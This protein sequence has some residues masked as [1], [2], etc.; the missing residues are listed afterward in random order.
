[1]KSRLIPV[2]INTKITTV[3]HLYNAQFWLYVVFYQ[4]GFRWLNYNF[5]L[6]E[7]VHMEQ[8]VPMDLR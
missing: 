7:F 4:T 6:L 5:V 3:H 8:F 1:M 2:D